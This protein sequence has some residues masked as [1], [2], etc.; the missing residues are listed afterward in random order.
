M[1]TRSFDFV[2]LGGGPA[3]C[4]LALYAHKSNLRCLIIEKDSILG[5]L[6]RSWQWSNFIVDTGPHIF[7]SPDSEIASDW[8]FYFDDLLVEGDYFSANYLRQY[9]LYVDY[10]LSSDNLSEV[11]SHRPELSR[12]LTLSPSSPYALA[13]ASSFKDYVEALVGSNLASLFFKNYP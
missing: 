2:I 6:G 8:C 4:S 13:S 5:G 3:A 1:D 11:A 9:D 7:H 12:S 10:P